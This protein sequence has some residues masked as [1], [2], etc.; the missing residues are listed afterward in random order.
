MIDELLREM[1]PDT[2]PPDP[3]V[4]LRARRALLRKTLAKRARR[5]YAVRAVVGVAAAA[6]V[7]GVVGV[8]NLRGD[9]SGAT[10]AAAILNRSATALDSAPAGGPG[11]YVYRKEIVTSWDY[12]PSASDPAKE[13]T[14]PRVSDG[15]ETWIPQ[16]SARPLVQRTTDP[17]GGVTFA[18]VDQDETDARELYQQ[19]PKDPTAMLKALRELTRKSG[20]EDP[21]D[22]GVVWGTAFSLVADPLTPDDIRAG[23]LRALALMDGVKVVDEN[24]GI[25]GTTGVALGYDEKYA[26]QMIF[27]P[28]DGAFLGVRGYP[29]HNPNWVGPDKPVWTLVFETRI[30]DSAPRPSS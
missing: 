19:D 21:N 24:A 9:G 4:T 28:A 2:S 8:V 20:S 11:Q 30:V 29:A 26:P 13:N 1:R 18:I 16:D 22:N 14:T 12:G 7:L 17:Q 10:A 6:S 25:G 15:I 3:L 27:D 23:V 5:R